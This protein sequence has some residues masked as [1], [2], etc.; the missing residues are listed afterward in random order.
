M[1]RLYETGQEPDALITVID[2]LPDSPE[3]YDYTAG[4]VRAMV[5]EQM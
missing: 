1:I 4:E 3:G 2:G 5:R